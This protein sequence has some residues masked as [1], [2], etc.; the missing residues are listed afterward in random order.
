MKLWHSRP[1]P[2]SRPPPPGWAERL[3]ISPLL[4]DILWRRG[5]SSPEEMDAFLSPGL[6]RLA[7]PEDWPGMEHSARV[8]A[9]GLLAGKTFAVWGDYDVDG[10]SAAVLVRD[11]LATHGLA[12]VVHLPD[13]RS[14]GY[15]LNNAALERLAAQGVDLLLTVDCGISDVQ[16]VNRARELGICVVVSDHHLPPPELPKAHAICNP[17]LAECPCPHLAGV[18]VA[19]F[20]MSALNALLTPHTGARHDMRDTLDLVALGTLA[21]V[22][23]LS[24]Q[25]RILVKN[26][27]LKIAQAARPGM[28]ALKE[29]CGFH[30]AASLSGSQVVFSLAP[31]V[32]AAGRLGQAQLAFDLLCAGDYAAALELA[33]ALDELNTRRRAEEERMYLEARAQAQ[34]RCSA[35]GL[36]LYKPDW[37][38][39]IIG[40][41]ASRIVEDM[42][43]PALVLCDDQSSL[44]GSGRSIHEFDL[45]EALRG[46]EDIFLAFGGHRLAA[47]LR[48]ECGKLEELRA[49]FDAAARACLGETPLT[50]GLTLDGELDFDKAADFAFLKELELLQPFGSG[51]AE[52]VFASPPLVIRRRRAF[53]PAKNHVALEVEDPS[54]GVTLHAKAWRQAEALPDSV[55]G[56]Q[57]RLAY[58]PRMDTWNGAPSVDVRIKDWKFEEKP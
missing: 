29:A 4:L 26:G 40:I 56:R 49:R 51:N 32:N 1:L 35:M 55:C 19:F 15:G 44:K 31:R 46:L 30:P 24:G 9:E 37:H 47:G 6:R 7:P 5:L 17:R 14:E 53:G 27:L 12:A 16:A 11:V 22:V 3:N 10:V 50:A 23:R 38:P 34:E 41:V 48:L 25:N 58:T 52:P 13:R 18:G 2:A 20:L 45:Y 8:L 42:Y 21:D 39:G 33:R 57:I 43:R 28:A 54:C 36:V